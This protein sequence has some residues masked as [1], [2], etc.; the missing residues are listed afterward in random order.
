MIGGNVDGRDV[1]GLNEGKN[2][3]VNKSSSREVEATGA[4]VAGESGCVINEPCGGNRAVP[5]NAE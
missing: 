3:R 5:E 1:E 2:V 4:A